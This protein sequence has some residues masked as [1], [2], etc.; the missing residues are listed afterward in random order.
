MFCLA[1]VDSGN[2][3][4]RLC[5]ILERKGYVFEVVATPCQIARNGC[6]YC[7]KLPYQLMDIIINEGLANNIP[8]KEVYR[9]IPEAFKNKY[10]KIY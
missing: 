6:G 4:F 9:I 8:V 2:Y 5:T 3:A 10:E 7:I 1:L